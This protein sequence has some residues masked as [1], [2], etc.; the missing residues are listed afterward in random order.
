[1]AA[2]RYV[3]LNPVRAGL[4]RRAQDWPWSSAR[5]HLKGID[6]GLTLTAPALDRIDDFASLLKGPLTEELFEDLRRAELTG[7]PIGSPAFLARLEKRLGRPLRL[8]KRG[9]KPKKHASG[10]KELNSCYGNRHVA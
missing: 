9:P 8:Q 6:D 4:V 3:T 5:A 2:L 1:M 10:E 7:R